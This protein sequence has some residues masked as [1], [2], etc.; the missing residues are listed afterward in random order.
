MHALA[1][2]LYPIRRSL[3]G[4][5]VRA[6]LE[7]IGREIPLSVREVP[8][9]TPAFDWTVPREWNLRAAWIEG[10]TGERVV[11]AADSSL[12]VLGYSVPVR[13]RMPLSE[14]RAHLFTLPDAPDLIP[15]RT[16][17]YQERWGFCLP[18]SQ[19][20]A[21]SDGE[22]EVCIDSTLADGALT[23]G[24]CVLEGETDDEV[25][26]STHVCHP[27]LANDNLSGIVVATA[28]AGAL[29]DARRRH[30]FR[31]L[32]I[33]GTIGSIVWLARNEQ[34]A[35]R[36]RH[37]LVLTC[38]GDPG[39]PTYKRSRRGD[40]TIDRA[41]EHA[42]RHSGETFSVR[43]F[44]P[45]G[46]DER[47]YCSPGF[48]LPVGCLMRT[49]WGEFPAY[50]TSADNL[51]LIRPEALASTLRTCTAAIETIERNATYVNSNP[52]CEPQL[53]KRGLYEATGGAADPRSA[54]MAML[55][56][57][58]GSD[59]DSSLLDIAE[60]AGMPFTAI[61]DAADRLLEH[62]LLYAGR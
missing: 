62:G 20:E 56:V 36:I 60:R 51:D 25:L 40:C 16:S 34:Q 4:D 45:Y 52:K 14:L 21:L 1:A 30:T 3:T 59:G 11:D 55:W 9:G 54:Q 26:I 38:V 46:Y 28:L 23:Y 57:L 41:V 43:D 49:P 12:H 10:P 50:H 29:A 15:Y 47:Q 27:E 39:N 8:S 48:D 22:Y 6:T 18:H 33:P 17:Y 35:E 24:E 44:T 61:A 42:L 37:G 31:F 32:F 53:G 7:R 58:N 13:R 19:A 5:G 2:E